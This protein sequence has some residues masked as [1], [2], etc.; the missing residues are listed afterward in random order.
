MALNIECCYAEC[1]D[2]SNVKLRVILLSI[3]IQNVVKQSVIILNVVVLSVVAPI[4]WL[5]IEG[6]TEKVYKFYWQDS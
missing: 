2:Y 3:V 1:R 5:L 4:Y 6:A